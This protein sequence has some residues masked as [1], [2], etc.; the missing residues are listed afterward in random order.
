M[1][2]FCT[3][4]DT[5][6]EA[7]LVKGSLVY[8]GNFKLRDLPFW[9]C[10]CCK[11]FVGCHHKTKNPTK[12]L[13]C[14]ANSELKKARIHIHNLMDPLWKNKAIARKAIYEYLSN[15]L[16]YNYHTSSIK[17]INEARK[18]Y[19]LLLELRKSVICSFNY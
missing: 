1:K 17:S 13:G 18:V 9:Q 11:N 10:P 16:G 15:N 4:C 8:P 6:V 19:K 5:N 3:Q 2:I 12:P 7:V 14:I